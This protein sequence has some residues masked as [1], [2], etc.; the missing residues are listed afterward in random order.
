M[1]SA[2]SSSAASERE[3]RVFMAAFG[4]MDSNKEG[5]AV[6][7]FTRVREILH[8]RGTGFRHLLERSQEAE[9]L[10][11]EMGRQNTQLLRENAALRARDS[12]PLATRTTGFLHLV[13]R[14]G[15]PQWDIAIIA[16]VAVWAGLGLLSVT[17]A[18]TLSA[19][20]LIC[21]A[22]T[23]WFSLVRFAIGA[24]CAFVAYQTVL[25]VPV[26]LR[27]ASAPMAARPAEASSPRPPDRPFAEAWTQR[28]AH[29]DCGSYRLQS[30][31][32]C[33]RSNR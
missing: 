20:I 9:R 33:P 31:Y 25:P 6:A 32:N 27:P 23:N 8:R 21:A 28:G 26:P 24:L 22:F 11:D 2:A 17:T 12:R 5:E 18:L 4:V 7:A 30:G 19:G 13:N 16:I 15:V 29:V 10:N 3:E 1:S 14:P